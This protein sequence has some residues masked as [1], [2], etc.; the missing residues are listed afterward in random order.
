M[1]E[2]D[3]TLQTK[4]AVF[5]DLDGTVYLGDKLIDGA[6]RF[7]EYLRERN[8]AH[9]FLS[10][11]SSRSK[12]DYVTKLSNLGIKAGTDQ[13]ILSTD[14][15]I[16]FLKEQ[17]I[18][19][20]YV[21]GTKSMKCM[22]QESDIN[23]ESSQ[24]EYVIL[25]YDTELTYEKLCK[26]VLLLQNNIE[27]VAT[28]CDFV[29]PTPEGP[30][31]DVGSMLALIEK[32]TGKKPYRIFGKPN[33]EMIAHILERH[34]AKPQDAVII[35]DRIYTDMELANRIGCDFILVLSGETRLHD[36][37]NLERQP[38]LVVNSL[39]DIIPDSSK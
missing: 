15:V 36:I 30:I 32:A 6:A 33:P 25:G 5:L 11:N 27:L 4:K 16:E 34:N 28:H 20:V 3:R 35:G 18:K 19:R 37:K 10:N 26:A 9:Y 13:I 23:P 38:A 8:I 14:G 12:K 22:F 7:L 21:V 2:F 24:P 29:C 39:D 17:R 1:N 31:P